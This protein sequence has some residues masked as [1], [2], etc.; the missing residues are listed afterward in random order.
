MKFIG[1]NETVNRVSLSHKSKNLRFVCA[2]P[3]RW[4]TPDSDFLVSTTEGKIIFDDL[5]EVDALISMLQQFKN[6]CSQHFDNWHPNHCIKED[7]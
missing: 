7:L 3:P 5:Y 4:S 6:E 1:D 2:P